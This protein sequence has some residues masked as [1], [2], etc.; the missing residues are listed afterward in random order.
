M[1][2]G[3]RSTNPESS[4][5]SVST[6]SLGVTIGQLIT[7]R[8]RSLEKVLRMLLVID[9]ICQWFFRLDLGILAFIHR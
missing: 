7:G 2:S 8:W 3:Y 1:V 9:T 4:A 6:V 5:T